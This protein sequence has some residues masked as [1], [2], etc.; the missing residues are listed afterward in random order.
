LLGYSERELLAARFDT[1]T[2]PDEVALDH[3]HDRRMLAGEVDSYQREKRYLHKSGRLVW[4]L[5]SVSLVRGATGAPSYFIVQA[6][7]TT[8][9][10]HAEE[11]LARQR[12]AR[13][14]AEKLAAMGS[15]LAGVAHELN[16]PLA[17]VMGQATMLRQA[18]A[19]GPLETRAQRIVK[20]ADRCARIVRN[21]LA[22]A[23]QR[24]PEQREVRLN[25]VVEEAVELLAYPLRVDEVS[26]TLDLDAELPVL[27]ADPQQLHQLV[28]NLV[29]NALQALREVSTP[30]QLR[31][32]TRHDR[33][34]GRIFIEVADNGPGVLPENQ[35][36]VFEPFFTTKPIGQ[37]TGLGLSL[38]RGIVEGHGGSIRLE[39]APGEGTVFRIELPI[40][41][42][43]P[44]KVP[45]R[46]AAVRTTPRTILV[47]DDEPDFL[48]LMIEVLSNDGH[49][50]DTTSS[51]LM[52]L[53]KLQERSYDVILSDIRM[54]GLDG[55]GLFR[56]LERRQPELCRRMI[57]LTGDT[58]N[59]ET[60]EFLQKTGAMMLAK[61]CAPSDLRRAIQLVGEMITLASW[62]RENRGP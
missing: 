30:R 39:S 13:Y 23:R 2:H 48:E 57:F 5:A 61:P 29:S 11:E 21:F 55:P 20:A 44:P 58:V 34:R 24:K 47:I 16:N 62:R 36:R 18:A 40:T 3:E 43:E 53:E 41:P 6:Q 31:C 60:Q 56:A 38:C 35:A 28:V 37:G 8:E 51:G 52:A 19:G 33:A 9:R 1:V 12:E 22:L 14:Q 32:T 49:Q 25:E 15:L 42:P 4:V 10:H 54:P 26:V 7:D 17:V 46:S 50:I 59:S 45:E 27:Q